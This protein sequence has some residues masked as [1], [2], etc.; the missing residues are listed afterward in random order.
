MQIRRA[1]Q[2]GLPMWRSST[3]CR[4]WSHMY[5]FPY[6]SSSKETIKKLRRQRT[7]RVQTM[8]YHALITEKCKVQLY[9]SFPRMSWNCHY[10]PWQTI[11]KISDDVGRKYKHTFKSCP[12]CK[13]SCPYSLSKLRPLLN[14]HDGELNSSQKLPRLRRWLHVRL[15]PY[16]IS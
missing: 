5:H 1:D 9:R 12:L 16:T 8:T 14:Y 10:N 4:C 7:N 6:R 3:C 15:H 11:L 2:Y 13:M